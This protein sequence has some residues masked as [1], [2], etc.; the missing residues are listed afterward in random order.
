MT[1]ALWFAGIGAFVALFGVVLHAIIY[2]YREGRK[3]QRLVAVEQRIEGL[4]SLEALMASMTAH[5]EGVKTQVS[6]LKRDL[7]ADVGE[8]NH[9]IR[10]HMMARREGPK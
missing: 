3:E 9:I 4:P 1:P 6:E 7:K 10:N 2:A 5:M 8:I